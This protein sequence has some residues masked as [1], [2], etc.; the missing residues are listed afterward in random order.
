MKISLGIAGFVAGITTATALL[1]VVDRGGVL[2]WATLLVGAALLAKIWFK[3]SR[4]DPGLSV[5]LAAV[6][7]MAW[8]GTFY[9]VISTWESGEVVELV[10]DASNGAH[11]ARVWVLDIGEHPLVYYDAEPEVAKSLLEG[12]PLQL[13]RAR[14]VSNRI[15]EATRVD[16]LPVDEANRIFETM[17]NKY[18]DR[19]GAADIYYSMLGRSRDRIAVVAKLIEE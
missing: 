3:P 13:T 1:L 4:I 8:V 10:I 15:P 5:G 9:Y 7:A 2:A 18:G 17:V 14:E 11:T 16:T 12:R 6:S 19:V